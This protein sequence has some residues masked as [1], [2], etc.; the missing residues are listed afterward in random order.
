MYHSAYGCP[1]QR[2][3]DANMATDS[4]TAG[5]GLEIFAIRLRSDSPTLV[6]PLAPGPS[7]LG[8]A[9]GSLVMPTRG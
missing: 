5:R 1:S 4:R 9:P 6:F 7:A 2:E 3:S 8:F